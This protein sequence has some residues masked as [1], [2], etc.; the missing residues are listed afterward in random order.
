MQIPNENLK[1]GKLFIDSQ[2]QRLTK[3]EYKDLLRLKI[4]DISPMTEFNPTGEQNR[5][6]G[7]ID[8]R[9]QRVIVKG[10]ITWIDYL[11]N[12]VN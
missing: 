3:K 8:Q 2:E 12:V 9:G 10:N 6:N 11:V 4:K 7:L 5:Q 1:F